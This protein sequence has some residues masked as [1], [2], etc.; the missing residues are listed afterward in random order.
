V[1]AEDSFKV[2]NSGKVNINRNKAQEKLTGRGESSSGCRSGK[3]EEKGLGELHLDILVVSTL[4]NDL[5]L[6]VS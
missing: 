3:E 2:R 6:L 1:S 5:C 4:D